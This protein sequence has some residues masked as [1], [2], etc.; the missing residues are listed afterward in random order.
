MM[1]QKAALRLIVV[2]L[3]D[4]NNLSG[5]DYRSLPGALREI[6]E[7]CMFKLAENRPLMESVASRVSL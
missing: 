7:D 3:S 2:T 1:T 6:A 5:D 4:G